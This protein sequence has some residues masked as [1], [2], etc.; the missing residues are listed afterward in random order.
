[1]TDR[2]MF[3]K[4][5]RSAAK[6]PARAATSWPA[7]AASLVLT[8]TTLYL[9][10]LYSDLHWQV[11]FGVDRYESRLSEELRSE[12]L[13]VLAT[14]NYYRLFGVLALGFAVWSFRGRPRWPAWVALA[15][16]GVALF[17]SAIVM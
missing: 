12:L 13:D 16:S 8:G 17:V 6:A 1:M 14:L 9:F 15:A 10:K 3:A 11:L 5:R 4:K 7:A 2:L